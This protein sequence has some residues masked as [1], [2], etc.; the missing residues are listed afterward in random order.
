MRFAA[1][2]FATALCALAADPAPA[3]VREVFDRTLGTAEREV[4]SLAEAMP[5]DKFTFAPTQGEF[6]GVRTFAQQ[7]KHIAFTNYSVASAVLGEKNPSQ[8]G[9]GEN[10]PDTISSKEQVVKYLKESFAYVHR[11]VKT[12]TP[13]NLTERVQNP[14][15]AKGKMTRIEAVNIPIWHTFDHYG[16]MVEY[17]RMNGIIPPASRR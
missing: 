12:L 8:S 16:Q 9:P 15:N 14:F 5:A 7:A 10:G 13:E 4:V 17:G 6:K 11:A 1:L 2:L 3:S